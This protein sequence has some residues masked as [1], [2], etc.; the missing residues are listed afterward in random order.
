[1]SWDMLLFSSKQKITSIEEVYP[2]MFV[3]INF[4]FLLKKHFHVT[5]ASDAT[6]EIQAEDYSIVF[7]ADCENESFLTCH[8]Y[9]EKALFE[10]IRISRV[11]NWQIFD[12]GN[13]QM[14][15]LDHPEKNGYKN[16]QLYLE[17]VRNS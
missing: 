15:D 17:Q 16:F 13:G 9:G 5:K 12:T 1:M 11:Y 10:L 2:D 3:P 8:L 6:N 4:D 14:L 7:S